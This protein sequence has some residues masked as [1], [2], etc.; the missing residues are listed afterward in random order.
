MGGWIMSKMKIALV[1]VYDK[2]TK[3]YLSNENYISTLGSFLENNGYEIKIHSIEDSNSQRLIAQDTEMVFTYI[4]RYNKQ[5]ILDLCKG[6]KETNRN[7]KICGMGH[8]PTFHHEI[9]MEEA[10]IIDY[11]ISGEGE[12]ASLKL[13]KALEN[14]E[15]FSHVPALS[16]REEGSVRKNE[17]TELIESLDDIPFSSREL[18]INRKSRSFRIQ[19]SRGCTR[20]CSFCSEPSFWN[21]FRNRSI[22]NV[23]DEIEAAM[24]EYHID[25]FRIVDNTYETFGEENTRIIQLAEEIIKRGITVKYAY[26]FNPEYCSNLNDDSLILLKKSGLYKVHIKIES[27]HDLDLRIYNKFSRAE[28]N[29]KILGLFNKYDIAVEAEF[30]N[31][32]GYSSFEGLK[33]NLR[34]LE[35]YKMAD[36][37]KINSRYI[38]DEGSALYNMYKA[39]GLICQKD[40][41]DGMG[42]LA[43]DNRI[44]KLNCLMVDYFENM[45]IQLKESLKIVTELSF[46]QVHEIAYY[47]NF[48]RVLVDPMLMGIVLDYENY[49]N[50]KIQEL[51]AQN[52]R[53]FTDM[54]ELAEGDWTMDKANGIMDEYFRNE[55]Y[56]DTFVELEKKNKEFQ[57]LINPRSRKI[58]Y[59]KHEIVNEN[60]EVVNEKQKAV[61]QFWNEMEQTGSP[62]IEKIDDEKSIVT[63]IYKGNSETKNVVVWGT[64]VGTNYLANRMKRVPNTDVWYKTFLLPSDIEFTYWFSVNEPFDKDGMRRLKESITD[65]LNPEQFSM[66]D[67]PESPSGF[68]YIASHGKMPL[69]PP[70]KWIYEKDSVP[71]GNVDK[72]YFKSEILDNDRRIWAYTP[73]GYDR[74]KE[75][76]LLVLADGHDYVLWLSAVTILDNLINEELIQPTVAIFVSSIET[77]FDELNCNDLFNQFVVD[78]VL[79][80]AYENYSITKEPDKITVGGFSLGGVASA[81]LGLKHSEIFGNILSQSGAFWI[82]S[83][84]DKEFQWLIDQYRAVSKLPLNFYITYGVLEG[85]ARK[86]YSLLRANKEF[87][88]LLKEKEYPIAHSEFKS[89]HDR[90]NWGETLAEGLIAL[91]EL[92]N[93][94]GE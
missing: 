33:K 12:M 59:L 38:L 30:I 8:L 89:G 71:K 14:N 62:I 74:N 78:E 28:D 29:E 9:L 17:N 80:L 88:E 67:D 37:E 24:K 54:L 13:L 69:V 21:T 72:H 85:S 68:D 47:K 58:E 11:C 53:W 49:I 50:A 26:N 70:K 79:P 43:I 20:E 75:Y 64:A 39:N 45:D 91:T 77:R 56:A 10:E 90:L 2:T 5:N 27:N 34:F 32:N 44:L 92:N 1:Y 18:E 57:K 4:N 48:E 94:D 36:I 46:E 16:Y 25:R 35:K 23:V 86:D 19:A 31:I 84:P 22:I 82:Y 63:F 51:G 52:I 41:T 87:I 40:Y 7:I 73:P 83:G 3:G 81:Y 6:L 61:E 60:L 42:Y 55:Y 93:G 65:P 76:D 66:K 15:D